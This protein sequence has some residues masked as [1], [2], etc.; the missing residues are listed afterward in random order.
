MKFVYMVSGL[1]VAIVLAVCVDKSVDI[2]MLV[3][4]VN[5][6]ILVI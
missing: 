6:F 1:V 5:M 3:L 4:V 2:Q